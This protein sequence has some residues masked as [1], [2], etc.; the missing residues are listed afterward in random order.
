MTMQAM[1]LMP[2]CAQS[3]ITSVV[4]CAHT[5]RKNTAGEV[6]EHH[7]L[8]ETLVLVQD[9]VNDREQFL[10]GVCIPQ[11]IMFL[12]IMCSALVCLMK[13]C[14]ALMEALKGRN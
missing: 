7:N 13:A 9:L 1:V 8:M 5:R 11:L 12:E 2:L 3:S 14:P 4:W 10:F 6:L